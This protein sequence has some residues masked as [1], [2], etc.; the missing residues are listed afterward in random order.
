MRGA[1]A[2]GIDP[3]GGASMTGLEA[4]ASAVSRVAAGARV[5]AAAA[6]RATRARA[7]R[8]C[9]GARYRATKGGVSVRADAAKDA[10]HIPPGLPT[11]P[12]HTTNIDST[13]RK[14][15]PKHKSEILVCLRPRQPISRARY[16]FSSPQH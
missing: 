11:P 12:R 2:G 15:V 5:A 8:S 10:P 3:L 6:L 14:V 1:Y 16:A 9:R 13:V 4:M 7:G